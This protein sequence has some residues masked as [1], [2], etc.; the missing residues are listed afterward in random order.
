[1]INCPTIG[2]GHQQPAGIACGALGDYDPHV[3]ERLVR[4]SGCT[5][6]PVLQTRTAILHTETAP[7]RGLDRRFRQSAFWGS[8]TDPPP[9]EDGRGDWTHAARAGFNG[10]VSGPR[11]T[12][13]HTSESGAP[14]LFW[15][16]EENGDAVYF[17]SRI[18]PLVNALP[19]GTRL[20][21]DWDC[22]SSLLTIGYPL[23]SRTPF[24]AV[25][26]LN[27]NQRLFWRGNKPEIK[28]HSWPWA[29]IETTV[30]LA[31]G[32]RM[33]VDALRNNFA[34]MPDDVG[35]IL[36]SGGLDSRL[37]T[38]LAAERWP[39]IVSI[40]TNTD[41]GNSLEET[42]AVPVARKLGIA[43][44]YVDP[45]SPDD[46]MA[47]R[48][49]VGIWCDFLRPAHPWLLNAFK[50]VAGESSR[51]IYGFAETLLQARIRGGR[52]HL[53]D[54]QGKPN[55]GGA[56]WRRQRLLREWA[57]NESFNQ[58]AGE[59]ARQGFVDAASEFKG[60]PRRY[61]FTVFR[62]YAVNGM[63][64][65]QT[66]LP[67]HLGSRL[68]TPFVGEEAIHALMSIDPRNAKNAAVTDAVL[69]MIDPTLRTMPSTRE[70]PRPHSEPHSVRRASPPVV[71]FYT[72]LL[73]GSDLRPWFSPELE[74]LVRTGGISAAP[75]KIG[76]KRFYAVESIANYELW[77][78]RYVDRLTDSEPTFLLAGEAST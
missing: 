20:E 48:E 10:L 50:R 15:L 29:D 2:R 45:G 23:G 72:R 51:V 30:D 25:K 19:E 21:P 64:S 31:T 52:D 57:F 59:P 77:R 78:Q 63:C 49:E 43:N 42:L 58:F 67:E 16:H 24:A 1:M 60:H 6:E 18:D 32:A 26:R 70:R 28:L 11:E 66:T 9:D 71:D 35:A 61:W 76:H 3:L 55:V 74:E 36:L 27:P 22:W 73:A 41:E 12:F 62:T 75:D 8:L 47:Q 69:D 46:Y 17:A 65:W 40:T 13:L 14:P 34:R 56:V 37:Y 4:L 38:A 5:P 53:V 33:F 54:E 7:E 39:D 44:V 68:A